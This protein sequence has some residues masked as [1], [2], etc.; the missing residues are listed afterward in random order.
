M[1]C[2][3]CMLFSE[4][5]SLSKILRRLCWGATYASRPIIATQLER[6]LASSCQNEAFFLYCR[7]LEGVREK[8]VAVTIVS[9]VEKKRAYRA[10]DKALTFCY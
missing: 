9:G 1:L 4:E 5:T 8:P 2:M 10:N 7:A 6:G 3:L